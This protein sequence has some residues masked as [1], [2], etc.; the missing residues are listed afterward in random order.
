MANILWT[1]LGLAGLDR[2]VRDRDV[3]VAVRAAVSPSAV[4][5]GSSGSAAIARGGWG[6]AGPGWLPSRRSNSA[7]VMLGRVRPVRLSGPGIPPRRVGLL[8]VY[9]PVRLAAGVPGCR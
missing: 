7:S 3:A 6:S 8:I 4:E 5:A 2:G 1:R 9:P